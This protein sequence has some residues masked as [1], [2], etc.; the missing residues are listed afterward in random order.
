MNFLQEVSPNGCMQRY[1]PNCI[2]D[3]DFNRELVSSLFIV[4]LIFSGTLLMP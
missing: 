2:V 1:D 3:Y 4:K